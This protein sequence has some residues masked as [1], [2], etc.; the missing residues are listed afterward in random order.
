MVDVRL[1]AWH[2][3]DAD[4]TF[5]VLRRANAPEMM[6]H[7]GGPESEEKLADRQ[8]RYREVGA[9]GTGQMFV[10][11]ADGEPAGSVG[12]WERDGEYETGWSV[13]PEFQGRGIAVTALH[14]VIEHARGAGL[15]KTMHAYPSIH[16]GASNAVC[17]KAG[18]ILAGQCDFEYPPGNPV[19]G[20]DW[21]LEL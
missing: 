6:N 2:D 8:R 1:L 15:H 3:G 5:D 18:M 19:R 7:L 20:N 14:Q 9:Q 16:N 10:I 4:V 21:Y 13:L 17:R 11:L 12:Y